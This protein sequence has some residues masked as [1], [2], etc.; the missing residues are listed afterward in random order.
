VDQPQTVSNQ[1]T[2][3]FLMRYVMGDCEASELT[4]WA[5]EVLARHDRLEPPYEVLL[6]EV[7]ST[8]SSGRFDPELAHTLSDRLDWELT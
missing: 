6:Q 1:F 4:T 2:R 7:L 8:L 5:Q 3:Q